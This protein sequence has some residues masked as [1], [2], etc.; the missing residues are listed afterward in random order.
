MSKNCT[1]WTALKSYK[2]WFS[3]SIWKKYLYLKCHGH[4]F[5]KIDFKWWDI[6]NVFGKTWIVLGEPLNLKELYEPVSVNENI[7]SGKQ[8]MMMSLEGFLTS[9][10]FWLDRHWWCHHFMRHPL[11]VSSLYTFWSWSVFTNFPAVLT[12]SKARQVRS[13]SFPTEII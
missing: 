8:I 6:F 2:I 12:K 1:M 5:V 10:A 13:C 9:T 4:F 7:L 3:R 11:V